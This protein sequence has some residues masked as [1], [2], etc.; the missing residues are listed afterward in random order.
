MRALLIYPLYQ[1]THILK[2]HLRVKHWKQH[3]ISLMAV[4]LTVW[5]PWIRILWGWHI[6]MDTFN[7]C[8]RPMKSES[9]VMESD[10]LSFHI[11]PRWSVCALK[12]ESCCTKKPRMFSLRTFF[13]RSVKHILLLLV[14][15]FK[16][17]KYQIW[18]STLTTIIFYLFLL[19]HSL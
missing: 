12:F 1:S 14:L 17:T 6:K 3:C 9:Q 15:A 7:L 4:F 8:P 11:L 16:E 13:L 2:L 18:C 5:T 19:I 10:N